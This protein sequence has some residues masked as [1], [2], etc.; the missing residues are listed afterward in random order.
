MSCGQQFEGWPQNQVLK[1]TQYDIKYFDPKSMEISSRVEAGHR[2][3]G[4]GFF[5]SHLFR[6]LPNIKNLKDVNKLYT[7]S[8]KFEVFIYTLKSEFENV[9]SM[10]P[11][12]EI[13][14][15]RVNLWVLT[16]R[17]LDL[18]S[19]VKSFIFHLR[20]KYKLISHNEYLKLESW[21]SVKRTRL[22]RVEK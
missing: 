19:I 14:N 15:L 3:L 2:S 12:I 21:M 22:S 9:A 17:N 1:C 11:C 18:V 5:Y 20:Y 8:C 13:T 6:A 4:R 10:R 16:F 7:E